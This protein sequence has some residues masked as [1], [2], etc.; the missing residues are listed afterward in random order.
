MLCAIPMLAVDNYFAYHAPGQQQ[1]RAS[2][3]R[4][5]ESTDPHPTPSTHSPHHSALVHLPSLGAIGSSILSYFSLDEEDL[6]WLFTMYSAP[7]IVLV[8]LGGVLIDKYGLVR[9]SLVFNAIMTLGTIV[10]AATPR[11]SSWTLPYL[12]FGRFLLGVGGSCICVCASAM[13]AR[14]FKHSSLTF[15]LGF[16]SAVVQLVGSAPAFVLL[17]FLLGDAGMNRHTPDADDS[18]P[19]NST[20]APTSGSSDAG[21][22]RLCMWVP[23]IVCGVSLVANLVYACLEVR[24]GFLYVATELEEEFEAQMDQDM[25]RLE[26]HHHQQAQQ[27]QAQAQK[28]S[29]PPT[30]NRHRST[31]DGKYSIVQSHD[32]TP[33]HVRETNDNVMMDTPTAHD[34][35]ASDGSHETAPPRT[36]SPMVAEHANLLTGSISNLRS[37]WL[38]TLGPDGS[39]RTFSLWKPWSTLRA[40]PTLFWLVIGMQC[41]LSPI[42]YSFSVF[43]PQFFMEKYHLTQEEAGFLT[44]L[45]YVAI[46]L[47][48]VFGFAID[49]VGYR[50]II[51][52]VAA[53]LVPLL[54]LVLHLTDLSPYVIVCGLG[55]AF[56]VTESNG[57]A[58]VADVTPSDLLGTAYG[59]LGCCTSAFMLFEPYLV[60]Y[61]HLHTGHYYWTTVLF[62][63][64]AS[65]G[66]LL[67]FVVYVY[68]VNHAN[69]MTEATCRHGSGGDDD[70]IEMSEQ[71]PAYP[72]LE[73]VF[74][75]DD[76]EDEEEEQLFSIEDEVEAM[77][78]LP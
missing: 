26:M 66:W 52:T 23:V 29:S 38:D 43:G 60:G 1:A 72:E 24:Y 62:I 22:V 54:F 37:L 44:S 15:A 5:P 64:V 13:I 76:E 2:D 56:A 20:D 39:S 40:M 70:A 7:N 77:E 49:K 14:W 78:D 47:A 50:C 41:L 34:P 21:N 32:V 30:P 35:D 6:A 3:R 67:T 57:L 25:M 75:Q 19:D 8:F 4:E 27:K 10:C 12:L 61:I 51:Q 69:L 16:N 18:T 9:T 74:E 11:D 17:P 48:P 42:L 71:N 68:D 55:I 63:C 53:S 36:Q 33:I 28:S 46:I 59:I 45:L 73:I 65:A 58:M 31:Q